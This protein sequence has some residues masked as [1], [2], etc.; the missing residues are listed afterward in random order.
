MSKVLRPIYIEKNEGVGSVL[1]RIQK[2]SESSLALVF[3]PDSIIFH[4]VLEIEF[5]KRELDKIN[6]DVVIITSDP[7]QAELAKGLGFKSS[8][9]IKGDEET[10]KFLEDFYKKKEEKQIKTKIKTIS[11][12]IKSQVS[13]IIPRKEQDKKSIKLGIKQIEKKPETQKFETRRIDTESKEKEQEE[14]IEPRVEP[15]SLTEEDI[16]QETERKEKKAGFYHKFKPKIPFAWLKKASLNK[17]TKN[18]LKKVFVLLLLLAVGVFVLTATF[19]F[20]RADVLINPTKEKVQLNIDVVF[21]AEIKAV[22]FEENTVPGQIFKT[23]K[24]VSKEFSATREEDIKRKAEGIIT[25][26]N[27]YSSESQTLVETTRFQ[28]PDGKIFRI[29]KTITVPGAKI[30]N[31]VII[32]SSI[33]ANVI[34]DG[35]GAD[36]N[37]KPSRFSIPGFEGT[38][39][40][41]GFYGESKKNMTGGLIKKGLVVGKDDVAAAETAL[42]NQLLEAAKEELKTQ[43]G[44]DFKL[45]EESLI[46]NIVES[47]PTPSL[48]EPADKF[49]M[50]IKALAQ[51]FTYKESDLSDLIEEKIALKISD[52]RLTLPKTQKLDFQYEKVD[53]L[54]SQAS[55]N[56]IVEEDISWK[57]DEERFKE[58]L[59]G[60]NEIE[61]REAIKLFSEIESA[62]VSLWPFWLKNIPRDFRKI[63]LTIDY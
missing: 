62:R 40:Y 35:A 48:G 63:R 44:S 10:N 34:A 56:L 21:D 9:D 2:T 20:P 18:P 32:P 31:G 14:K 36:Y 11:P 43:L 60:K 22:D 37:I 61:A 26:Y 23:T 38:D 27:A 25:I 8:D 24:T 17:A 33:E 4:N 52:K 39:K 53:F 12:L 57:I 30:E 46:A 13:D 6:K 47:I 55:F 15:I 59:A 3:P 16:K 50:S 41:K 5:L 19:V 51:A 45:I 42:K 54:S 49:T 1:G 28:S 29:T 7:A 58:V